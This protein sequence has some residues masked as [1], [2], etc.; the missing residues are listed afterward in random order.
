MTGGFNVSPSEVEAT[1]RQHP[2]V[3]DAAVVGLP[4]PHSGELVVAAI[5]PA[6]G[7]DALDVD[8]IRAFART[9]LTPYKVPRRVEV[10]DEL[11][12]SLIGKVLRR[13]VRDALLAKEA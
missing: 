8:D 13:Q 1:L 12:R 9:R 3:A 11:P 2:Q 6:P 10:V 5:I 4:D 7:V